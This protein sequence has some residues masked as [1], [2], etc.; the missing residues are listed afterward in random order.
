MSAIYALNLFD[1]LRP[2]EWWN[3]GAHRVSFC[4]SDH[5]VSSSAP[6]T[7]SSVGVAVSRAMESSAR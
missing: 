1:R 2:V 6:A 4:G 3:S 7:V 5:A